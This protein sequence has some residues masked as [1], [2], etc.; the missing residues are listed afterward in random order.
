MEREA[1]I[2]RIKKSRK[3]GEVVDLDAHLRGLLALHAVVSLRQGVLAARGVGL[4]RAEFVKVFAPG[5]KAPGLRALLER[6][7]GRLLARKLREMKVAPEEAERWVLADL[8]REKRLRGLIRLLVRGSQRALSTVPLDFVVALGRRLRDPGLI[9]A[10]GWNSIDRRQLEAILGGRAEGR[11]DRHIARSLGISH[12]YLV[13][14]AGY[15]RENTALRFRQEAE[16]EAEARLVEKARYEVFFRLRNRQEACRELG[17]REGKLGP[18]RKYLEGLGLRYC[19]GC[20]QNR[21]LSDFTSRRQGYCS[22]CATQVSKNA[23]SRKALEV[24][25]TLLQAK[26]QARIR[27]RPAPAVTKLCARTGCSAR[28]ARKSEQELREYIDR[29]RARLAL[30]SQE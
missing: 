21:P 14:L 30:A 3:T 19:P 23:W 13:Q 9:L 15:R 10:A 16:R 18:R 22:R 17:V 27:G 26:K 8:R 29:L 28:L 4:D 7:L 1:F 5:G 25:R 12:Q 24:A 11:P 6:D 2:Q 20:R